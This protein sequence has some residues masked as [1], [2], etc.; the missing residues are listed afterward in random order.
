MP[1]NGT[2]HALVGQLVNGFSF[3][4]SLAFC[5]HIYFERKARD[6]AGFYFK[7][8]GVTRFVNLKRL[9]TSQAKKNGEKLL[10]AKERCKAPR[11]CPWTKLLPLPW[12]C[13]GSE[14]VEVSL[15]L[16]TLAFL[17]FHGSHT[18]STIRERI[19]FFGIPEVSIGDVH[20]LSTLSE[21]DQV[22]EHTCGKGF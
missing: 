7:R 21:G 16:N 18:T 6:S 10:S 13:F 19:P 15:C 2:N 12:S 1:N 4:N 3:N 11:T 9:E 14:M 5:V 17:S 8:R 22:F 20:H